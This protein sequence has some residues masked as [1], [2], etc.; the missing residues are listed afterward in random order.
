MIFTDTIGN[1]LI[2]AGIAF[3][4][5]FGFYKGKYRFI[6]LLAGIGL[7]GSRFT[8]NEIVVLKANQNRE[9]ILTFGSNFDYTFQD[10]T[11]SNISVS[12]NTLVNDTYEKLIIEKVEYSAYSSLSSGD[13]IVNN[14]E[15]YSYAQLGNSVSYYFE[16]SPKTIRVKGGGST[17]R[18][19]LHK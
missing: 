17:T 5:V 13:N 10:G 14:I 18:Y 3:F 2:Y 12:S 1:Y 8:M 11:T 9:K 16:E 4:I 19:W 6:F 15:P 7:I